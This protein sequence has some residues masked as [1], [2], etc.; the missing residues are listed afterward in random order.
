MSDIY[1]RYFT[2]QSALNSAR[3][4]PDRIVISPEAFYELQHEIGR[5]GGSLL[6]EMQSWHTG[7]KDTLF[8][9]PCEIDPRLEGN[10]ISLEVDL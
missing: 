6:F 10:R 1:G 8:G 9:L 3:I 5:I 2:K 4:V 7:L